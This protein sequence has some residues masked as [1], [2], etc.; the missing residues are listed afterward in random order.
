MF[1]RIGQRCGYGLI[2]DRKPNC[3]GRSVQF[4]I[5][6]HVDAKIAARQEVGCWLDR[7]CRSTTLST[8]DELAVHPAEFG[9]LVARHYLVEMAEACRKEAD[10][11]TRL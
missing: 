10:V 5:C 9:K 2:P 4:R 11:G 3:G 8:V 7:S 6:P 1:T